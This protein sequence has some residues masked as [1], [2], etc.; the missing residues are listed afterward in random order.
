M[1]IEKLRLKDFTG[2]QK[3]LGLSE[4]EIDFTGKRGLIAFS[5]SNGTGKTSALESLSPW[6]QF[7]SR[8]GSLFHHVCTR[9]A[10]KELCFSYQGAQYRTLLKIDCQSEK[11]EGFIW[12]DGKSVCNGKISAYNKY[13]RDLL[14]SPNLFFS[15]VFCAQNSKK[16]S[17]MRTGELKD[18]F[19]EFLRLDRLQ[20]HEGTAKQAA[21]IYGGKLSAVDIRLDALQ[22]KLHGAEELKGQICEVEHDLL[23]SN[24]ILGNWRKRLYDSRARVEA[25]QESI[26]KNAIAIQRKADINA[27]IERLQAD[28][29][30]GR[31][32]SDAERY[33]LKRKYLELQ[34]EITK[35]DAILKD[36]D[37]I[38]NAAEQERTISGNIEAFTAKIETNTPELETIREKIHAIELGIGTLN[39][40]YLSLD[41]DQELGR[42]AMEGVEIANSIKEKQVEL[43]GLENFGPEVEA[44]RRIGTM[45]DRMAALDLKDPACQS[46]TCSFIVRAVEAQEILPDLQDDLEKAMNQKEVIE[47]A[48]NNVLADLQARLAKSKGDHNVRKEFVCSRMAELY[49][50]KVDREKTLRAEK[51]AAAHVSE[52]LTTC[53]QQVADLRNRLTQVKD[54]AGKQADIQVAEQRKADL[55]AVL[56]DVT[57][58]GIAKKKAWETKESDYKTQIDAQATALYE[59]EAEIDDAAEDALKACQAHITLI[60]NTEIPKAEKEIQ[61]ARENIAQLQGEL[62]K[63]AEAEKEIDTVRAEREKITHEIAEW[64]YIKNACGKN[65][66]QAMEI[67][68]AA[69]LIT[70]FANDLLGNAF[71]PLYSVKLITQDENGKECLDIMVINEEGEEILL[72]NLS[73]GQKVWNL[74]ALRLGMTL[75]SKSK[76]GRN[77]ETAFFDELDGPLDPENAVNFI[78]MYKAFMQVGDFN[79]IPFISHKTACRSM[80]DH[81]LAFEPGQNPEWR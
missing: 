57:E 25:L 27:T 1:K 18:L 41:N 74:M 76:S 13:I 52:I 14:G 20:A 50:A 23:V 11:Q 29:S 64:T 48:I 31:D 72:S 3:G 81:I 43:K 4:I 2:I 59:L 45:R 33:T 38:A 58:Q 60:E 62:A 70:G 37:A 36:K 69:P 15:S 51:L 65:G 66:L 16:L 78:Q 47:S 56:A 34:G 77:F 39:Q 46:K 79:M 24:D 67:D 26:N 68:G 35:L 9:T 53:R 21:A 7:A 61:A 80:A 5:G 32:A 30:K 8:D 10:E 40:E 42:L 44:L 22:E 63:M 75:L 6:P 73:G 55:A 19:A 17:D 49:A 54:L 12:V 71:G 28:L